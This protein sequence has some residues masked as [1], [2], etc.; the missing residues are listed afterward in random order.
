MG[1]PERRT[2]QGP[3]LRIA[4]AIDRMNAAIAGA[5]SWCCLLI[6]AVEFAAVVMRYAFG[7]G[8]IAIGE[9]ALYAQAAL[10]M[11]AAGWTL[12]IGGHVRVDV[13]YAHTTPRKRALVDLCGALVFL[14]PFAVVLALVSVPYAARSWS[15]LEHSRE[16]SGL[17]FVYLLKT[18]IPA[19]AFLMG[20]QGVSQAIR[21]ALALTRSNAPL[22]R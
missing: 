12:H 19:F 14:V 10:V 6:V 21:A 22:A 20:L 9:M 4:D 8:S 7:V 11:L 18:L 2:G 5:A 1:A 17:P 13:F 16:A 3:L 15:I